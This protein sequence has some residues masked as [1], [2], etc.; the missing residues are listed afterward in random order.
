MWSTY[1][2]A[3]NGYSTTVAPPGCAGNDAGGNPASA[4]LY[5][6]YY[7]DD[8]SSDPDQSFFSNHTP[9]L[10]RID[11]SLDFTNASFGSIVPPASGTVASPQQFSARYR[12]SLYIATAGVYTFYLTS[13]DAS[14][15]WFDNDA[16]SV[17]AQNNRAVISNGGSHGNI[18]KQAS[19]YLTAG[20]HNV[21]IHYGQGNGPSKLLWE[22]EGP[23][24]S[25]QVVNGNVLCTAQQPLLVGIPASVTYSPAFATKRIDQTF[26]STVPVVD[27]GG[28]AITQY[29]LTNAAA[30][31]AGIQV[32][33]DGV[34]SADLSVP[35][36][37]YSINLALVNSQGVSHF[38]AVYYLNVYSLP[39]SACIGNDAGNQSAVAGFY[40]EYFSGYYSDNPDFF[41]THTPAL[42]RVPDGQPDYSD[43]FFSNQS[44]IAGANPQQFSARYRGSLSIATA[45]VYT[46]HLTSDDASY[47]WLGSTAVAPTIVNAD[48][49]LKNGGTHAAATVSA[50]V[51]LD[52]GMHNLLIHYGN[53]AGRGILKLE[54]EGPGIARR[55]IPSDVL[56]SSQPR[57]VA[58]NDQYE[59]DANTALSA[60]SVLS[61]DYDPMSNALVLNT[62]PVTNPLHGT[63]TLYAD[64][65]F[66]YL[67]N[68]GYIGPDSFV[69][70]VCNSISPSNCS[71]ATVNLLVNDANYKRLGSV[72]PLANDCFTLTSPQNNQTGAVWCKSA[73]SLYNSF[74]I[75]FDARFS[76]AGTPN[77]NGGD[78]ITF[79]LQNQGIQALGGSGG[80][81]GYS[82]ITP[83]LSIEFD[84]HPNTGEPAEDHIAVHLNGNATTAVA[85]PVPA[86]A[87][88]TNIEDGAIHPVKIIWSKP[89][90]SLQIYFDGSLRLTYKNQLI[91]TLFSGNPSVYWGFTGSTGSNYNE[92]GICNVL[93]TPINDAPLAVNDTLA[94]NEDTHLTGGVLGNDADPNGDPLLVTAFVNLITTKGG[95]VSM[96][97]NGAFTYVP[98]LHFNGTDSFSY[99]VCDQN[100]V[101]AS[102]CSQGIVVIKVNPVND[103]S[104]T[105]NDTYSLDE[106]TSLTV[107]APGVLAND[108]DAEND[109]LTAVLATGPAHGTLTLNANG[110]F[111]YVPAP[112]FNGTDSFTYQ[113]NDGQLNSNPATVMITVNPVNDLPVARNDAYSTNEDTLL[114][115]PAPGILGN[116]T[117]ADNDV[118][119]AVLVT[120][121]VHGILTLN[122]N[123]SFT[124]VPQAD[125]NGSDSFNYRANDGQLN[126]NVATVTITINPV[127][128]AP[129]ANNDI[130]NTDEDT[131]LVV[132]APG[133]L[134]HDTDIDQDALTAVLVTAPAHGTLTLN[135]NGSFTYVPQA[136]YNGS[137][138]FIYQ[139]NDGQLNSSPATVT[140]TVNAVNDAPIAQDDAY[141][142]GEDIPLKLSAPGV[143][144]NDSDVDHDALTAVLVTN[145]AHGSL[146]LK[147]DGSFVYKPQADYNGSDSFTYRTNDG[148]LQSNV[149]TV[150]IT[151][152]PVNDAPV[153]RDDQLVLAE[154]TPAVIQVLDNDSDIDGDVLTANILSPP[155]YGTLKQIGNGIYQYTPQRNFHGEDNFTYEVCDNGT[156]RLCDQATVRLTITQV[157]DEVVLYE[158]ISPNDDGMNDSWII[159]NIDDYP[160][161]MVRIFNRWGDL[162]FEQP[163]YDNESKVWKGTTNRGMTLGGEE[164]P[165][166]T[167]F[168]SIE[169]SSKIIKKG[170][171][172]INR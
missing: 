119:T 164:L 125:Y 4:G 124:Y 47:L 103:A 12:G 36:G 8:F 29:V 63:V 104:V 136:D 6:E 146:T 138:S 41:R 172:V 39:P 118:L 116:D 96:A 95:K 32:G 113:A 151:I 122:A 68:A 106:D 117:D 102:R 45:G 18:T 13:D 33:P 108:T 140:I 94:T 152:N 14:F 37:Y 71:R 77:D 87:T 62:T 148:Q 100:P 120:N 97:S 57:P 23:G 52:A 169:L 89:D 90:S 144:A 149:A 15:L 73:L 85:G 168:Y 21:L 11:E 128:D 127:N 58:Q 153:A 31:P 24:V 109:A 46:F 34:I 84:T 51:L 126:S 143:L 110:G 160:K 56:C 54:Y 139:A 99:Q 105:N 137:A 35:A 154:D 156:P 82:G 170:Y 26:H 88:Q 16:L 86:S 65:T 50:S 2:L 64:G 75:S 112:N 20:L 66:G 44:P 141:S 48:A 165:N 157:I 3:G 131:P 166:G 40:A 67:P 74:E 123:G 55:V 129:V 38:Q 25:R 107:P 130:Y 28:N 145:P 19:V 49:L 1:A 114:S 158:G 81:M 101:A 69:Y 43:N 59:T 80:G 111:T 30:L 121:P 10:T 42:I 159:E 91:N 115:V 83:S 78:G 27:D 79:T 76:A 133:V 132:S 155:I 60:T 147:A 134:T 142:T 5:A 22:Y 9:A 171:V 161:N 17:P 72:I 7:A 135:A 93:F 162:V 61:N 150:N 163:D 70:E 92:Q 53:A 167:Y 98:A